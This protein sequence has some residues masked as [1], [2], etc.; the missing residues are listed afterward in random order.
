MIAQAVMTHARAQGWT[1]NEPTST[2]GRQQVRYAGDYDFLRLGGDRRAD[3]RRRQR[4]GV[5]VTAAVNRASLVQVQSWMGYS[6]VQTTAR[7]LRAKNQVDDGAI[8]ASAFA[9]GL[10]PQH[11]PRVRRPGDLL[12]ATRNRRRSGVGMAITASA[13]GREAPVLM[14]SS[15]L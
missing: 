8:L 6:H 14:R 11:P 3:R 13:T 1:D 12:R 5:D 7:Y 10:L 15:G 4:A 9:S 2:I